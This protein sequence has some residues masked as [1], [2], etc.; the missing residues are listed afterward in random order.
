MSST[1]DN[2]NA[3]EIPDLSKVSVEDVLRSISTYNAGVQATAPAV[4]DAIKQQQEI[5]NNSVTILAQAG[6][7]ASTVD[8]ATSA[9]AM[10]KQARIAKTAAFLGVDVNAANSQY[11][12]L[13]A[14]ADAAQKAKDDSLAIIKEKQSV[15]LLDN[16]IKYV[17]NQL[18]VNSDIAKH[19]IANAELQSA[20]DRIIQLNQE[21][22]TTFATEKE[23]AVGTTQA[24]AE[25]SAR[26]AAAS[27]QL[28][29]NDARIQGLQYGIAGIEK[30]NSTSKQIYD[31]MYTGFGARKMEQGMQVQLQQ[32]Q[33]AKEAAAEHIREFNINDTLRQNAESDRQ[34][35][36][37]ALK[38]IVD[39]INR[40]RVA[41]GDS[42]LDNAGAKQ[43]IALM[44][45]SGKNSLSNTMQF[46]YA[47]GE[48]MAV[49]GGEQQIIATSPS[50]FAIA[51]A[52]NIPIKTTPQ[53]APVVGLVSQVISEVGSP[54]SLDPTSVKFS[55][56]YAAAK[57]SKDPAAMAAIFNARVQHVFDMKA[58]NVN[59][60][61]A[62][63]PYN[64]TSINALAEQSPTVA[65][66]AFYSK[67]LAGRAKNGE[68]LTD[69]NKVFNA[70]LD[71]L[72]KG[73]ITLPEMLE[74]STIYQVGVNNA[75]AQR[76]I[77]GL[78][79]VVPR[80]GF[81]T[82]INGQ[83]IDITHP[84]AVSRAVIKALNERRNISILQN[85]PG[86]LHQ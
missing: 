50:Q 1:S 81:N 12:A 75:R 46:D 70:G 34:D 44:R 52:Q 58:A 35:A 53:Q 42:E 13:S 60:Q 41:R 14:Q 20:H 62:N 18:T 38:P 49:K 5:S 11:Q 16:P 61:D 28:K 63:N 36:I 4:Q 10:D 39:S 25:A 85:A 22:Q 37:D 27:A 82:S 40:G 47:N 73:T 43:I 65:G 74:M 71:A 55:Q 2:P 54:N 78:V 15:S 51:T 32:L 48:A 31:A 7:D 64:V 8:L 56:E 45:T 84:D 24:S 69:P 57:A 72:N 80:I 79:G 68:Q 76:N 9:A 59:P 26:M 19:N 83:V 17:F 66:T 77:Q 21:A 86:E 30:A 3:P 33:M 23:L 29:A 6:A 67:V